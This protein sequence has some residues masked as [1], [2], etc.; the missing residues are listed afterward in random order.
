MTDSD[1]TTKIPWPANPI[2]TYNS[3]ES[4]PW[5]YMLFSKYKFPVFSNEERPS[6]EEIESHWGYRFTEK[7][8]Q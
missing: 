3:I 5:G 8:L 2:E 6:D 1:E 4:G 7:K